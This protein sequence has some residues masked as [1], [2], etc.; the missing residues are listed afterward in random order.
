M[1]FFR[2]AMMVL[3]PALL[4]ALLCLLEKYSKVY[5]NLKYFQKRV[6]A[7][8][9][10]GL[11]AIY[12][13]EFGVNTGTAIYNTRDSAV[14]CAG[15]LFGGPAGGIAAIIGGVE[16]FLAPMWGVGVYTRY[17]CS[18]ATLMAGV[19][20]ALLR[21]FLLNKERP[22]LIRGV[23]IAAF[24]E[25]FHMLM[26]FVT[27][28]NDLHKAMS[29]VKE[30]TVLMVVL[31]AASVFLAILVCNLIDGNFVSRKG[32]RELSTQF[33]IGLVVTMVLAF[34]VTI[35][36]T[37][38]LQT[39]MF[40]LDT[41][42]VLELNL[43]DVADNISNASDTNLLRN[44]TRVRDELG[45]IR[46]ASMVDLTE[47]AELLD[48]SEISTINAD[49]II[50]NSTNEDFIGYD[51][52]SGNQSRVFN[53]LL[54]SA[55]NRRA[56]SVVQEYG[57]ISYDSSEYRK[58]AGVALNDGYIQVGYDADKFQR[59]ILS[60]VQDSTKYLHINS[61]GYI[62][63]AD[64]DDIIV[65]DRNGNEGKT[66]SDIGY[67]YSD[68][69]YEQ[70]VMYEGSILGSKVFF[71]YKVREGYHMIAAIPISDARFSTQL[72]MWMSVMMQ[73]LLFAILFLLIFFLVKSLVLNNLEKVDEGLSRITQGDLDVRLEVE[74]NKE[75]SNLSSGINTTVDKLKQLIA[76]ASA[77]IDA[78]LEFA[79][80]IQ[81]GSLPSV[82]PP[83][84][85]RTE[86]DI[87]AKMVTAK[88][89]GGDFYDFFFVGPDKLFVLIADV[90][91]KGIPAA[92][93]MMR[94]KTLIRSLSESG[95]PVNDIFTKANA[96][97]CQNNESGMFV[98]AW[99]ACID[100]TTGHVQ[101][102]NA[103]HNPPVLM[104]NGCTPE[105]LKSRAGLV[106]AGMEGL[107]YRLN[108]FDLA[109]GD[110]LYL[111]TDGVTE[112]TDANDQL[113]GEDRLLESVG[114]SHENM[115]D[116]C[117]AMMADI[118]AFVGEAPQ[119]DDI[120]MVAFKYL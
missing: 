68:S 76:E 116:V 119:F 73:I 77:R 89:V 32:L 112:A 16:R 97:L 109:K 29:I 117:D 91:G 85:N 27:H 43:D 3:L 42:N 60:Q 69:E 96:E 10:F 54:A 34:A 8:V 83:F 108:E 104:K 7:G 80:Q 58:Y 87:Y 46:N 6:I 100:V 92:L 78:E 19:F 30:M 13:T 36:F 2:F 105:L 81:S 21:R 15:L 20:T 12:G 64:R 1:M 11:V 47:I 118:N 22:S 40:K 25:V 111:Y 48:L 88:E 113:F 59:D 33:N 101:F 82:F 23:A 39:K 93:F 75:F 107:R 9:L 114:K 37:L 120:T 5:S 52:G 17:A 79:K 90:S 26:V 4:S 61:N 62:I 14:I 102:A 63:I 98:T 41:S 50:V 53:S 71:M 51:M 106:L 74:G 99:M 55:G 115:Q 66:L 49:G 86:F 18:I 57:P 95:I 110:V 67:T 72:S 65:S 38:S 103:G 70:S 45:N 28:P 94:A 35:S 24:M 84:P 31:N 56:N 44:T